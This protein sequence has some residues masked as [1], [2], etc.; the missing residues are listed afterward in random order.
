[1]NQ[2]TVQLE[3][4]RIATPCSADWSEMSGDDRV[5]FCSHC[6]LNVY[7]LSAMSRGEAEALVAEREGRICV[8]FHR[9]ADGTVLSRDCPVGLSAVR[10]GT[11]RRLRSMI[12]AGAALIAGVVGLDA[13][14]SE[15]TRL[16]RIALPRTVGPADSTGT[17]DEP[18]PE[19][20]GE[21]MIMGGLMPVELG[22]VEMRSD[23]TT[24]RNGSE[25]QGGETVPDGPALIDGPVG[26]E[27]GQVRD[28]S[29]TEM[30][31]EPVRA[32]APEES[33]ADGRTREGGNLR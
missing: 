12:A 29:P 15:G 23:D 24:G 30:T 28:I 22:E 11:M 5:R 1:M 14:A 7:N 20:S 25:A 32:D 33:S 16:G 2:P 3:S 10:Q 6:S 19:E 8:R 27:L 18:E 9:R 4:L 31:S 26:P 17:A 21:V 13:T